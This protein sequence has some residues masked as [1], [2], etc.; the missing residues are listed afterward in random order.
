MVTKT[1]G[2]SNDSTEEEIESSEGDRPV[3]EELGVF[4][5]ALLQSDC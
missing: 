1:I 2:I 4:A 5:A 3:I